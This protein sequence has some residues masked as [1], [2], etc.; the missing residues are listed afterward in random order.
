MGPSTCPK[1]TF[2]D[3]CTDSVSP[4]MQA[5]CHTRA[6]FSRYN[7]H[8]TGGCHVAKVGTHLTQW[9]VVAFLS[10]AGIES[11]C[12]LQKYDKYPLVN[13]IAAA[14][15]YTN[16]HVICRK[17]VKVRWLYLG[18]SRKLRERVLLKNSCSIDHQHDRRKFRSLTSDNM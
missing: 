5:F 1:R 15:Q 4:L 13:P 2:A 10:Q 8:A 6:I 16:A 14:P 3:K 17:N 7:R 12:D 11:P 9:F 18:F